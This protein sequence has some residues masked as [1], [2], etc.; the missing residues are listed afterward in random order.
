MKRISLY[1]I[2]LLIVFC[3]CKSFTTTVKTITVQDTII[4]KEVQVDTVTSLLS[5]RKDT[6]VIQK[7]RATTK[8]FISKD[9]IWVHTICSSD[10]IIKE[11][12]IDVPVKER[13]LGR[14]DNFRIQAF[15]YLLFLA[16]LAFVVIFYRLL[17]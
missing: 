5:A 16:F 10:T 17:K 2:L 13:K 7:E 4:T 14:W 9:S 11:I 12:K 6:I 8:Y 1:S 3:S 15:P